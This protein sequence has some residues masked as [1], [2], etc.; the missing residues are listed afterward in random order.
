MLLGLLIL[1]GLATIVIL[2]VTALIRKKPG[3]ALAVVLVPLGLLLGL[4]VLSAVFVVGIP[5]MHASSHIASL[6]GEIGDPG[7]VSLEDTNNILHVPAP[8]HVPHVPSPS[9]IS[10]SGLA[11][12]KVIFLVALVAAVLLV[13][14]L[15]SGKCDPDERRGGWGKAMLLILAVFIGVR[16]WSSAN[17]AELRQRA[18]QQVAIAR[19]EM[20]KAAHQMGQ[21]AAPGNANMQELWDQVNKPRIQLDADGPTAVMESTVGGQTVKLEARPGS[22]AKVVVEEKPVDQEGVSE[23]TAAVTEKKKTDKQASS[24]RNAEKKTATEEKADQA[25]AATGP[26]ADKRKEQ[27][28]EGK[29]AVASE[30]PAEVAAQPRPAWVD[31]PPKRVGNIW[32]EVVVAGDYETADECYQVA[33][34]LLYAATWDHLQQLTAREP[35]PGRAR[36]L[37]SASGLVQA[38]LARMVLQNMGIGIDY[39]RRQIVPEQGE[40]LETVE[41][42]FGPMKKLYTQLEFTPSVDRELRERWEARERDKRLMAVGGLGGLVVGIVGLAYGLLK[43]DTWTKG[44]YTK[45]LF[46]GFGAAIIGFVVLVALLNGL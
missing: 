45:R 9:Q 27:P 2:A 41:R 32:R 21:A 36:S 6:S 20:E 12:G 24:G 7:Y 28:A 10:Y 11:W 42:S 14:R 19:D 37:D 39:I 46:L 26:Q 35:S 34:E 15:M 22:G 43:I 44:Y 5:H 23:P 8:P 3:V 18:R 4:A 31:Q 17:V 29:A 25:D 13:M 33:D 30:S 38:P 40:Y 1:G 16:L